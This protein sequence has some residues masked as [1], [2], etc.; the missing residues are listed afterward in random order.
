MSTFPHNKLVRDLIP[1][2]IL[3]DGK[4]PEIR[5]ADDAEYREL[6]LAKLQE[7]LQE[8]L[9][10][11][12]PEELADILEVLIALSGCDGLSWAELVALA[13]QKRQERGSFRERIV[14]MRVED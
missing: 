3:R 8:Y 11:G 2:I 13:D 7:E 1:Q 10:S 4:Y 6:L 14:L 5:V 12:N 9:E